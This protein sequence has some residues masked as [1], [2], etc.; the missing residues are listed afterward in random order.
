MEREVVTLVADLLRAPKND[1]RGYVTSG[2]TEGN[3]YALYLARRTY[4]DAV[5]YYSDASHYSVAKAVDVLAMASAV[6]RSDGYGE[7]D[8]ADLR[9]QIEVRKDKAVVV[10]ANI[11]TTM[12]EAID[13]LGRIS[14]VL[15]ELE[16]ERRFLHADAALAGLPLALLDWAGNRPLFDFG[17]GA[18]SMIISGHKFIGSPVPC[19][20]VVVRARHAEGTGS[21]VAYIGSADTTIAGSRSGHAPLL[22]WYAL[23]AY[24]I[25]GLRARADRCRRLAAYTQDRLAAMGWESFRNGNAFTVVLRTVTARW[26]LAAHNGWSHIVCMPGVTRDQI[27]AFLGDLQTAMRQEAALKQEAALRSPSRWR[28]ALTWQSGRRSA[29]QAPTVEHVNGATS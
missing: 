7:M 14:A 29:V 13:D 6:V 8:Y 15:D 5:V 19:G 12:T 3:L 18:D 17:D 2:S 11:G 1:R 4:P 24:G 10:V 26:V 21:D 22:L 27:D 25:D 23:R 9:E 20:V 28:Q 16:I